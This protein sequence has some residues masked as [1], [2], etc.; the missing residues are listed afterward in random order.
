M[1][2]SLAKFYNDSCP[3]LNMINIANTINPISCVEVNSLK[4]Q[5]SNSTSPTDIYFFNFQN[6]THYNGVPVQRGVA[7]LF[8]SNVSENSNLIYEDFVYR[9]VISNLMNYSINPHFV[10]YLGSALDIPFNNIVNFLGQKN[11]NRN[12]DVKRN[13]IRNIYYA[14]RKVPG[15][16]ALTEN[17][18][19][20]SIFDR[21]IT[22]RDKTWIQTTAKYGY[23]ISEALP[24][25]YVRN[26]NEFTEMSRRNVGFSIT[27][28]NYIDISP[29]LT[30]ENKN[31]FKLLMQL[32]FQVATACYA[33]SLHGL[34]HNDLHAN[35]I[36][37][38]RVNKRINC[39]YIDGQIYKHET[40]YMVHIYDFDKSYVFGYNN[41][42]IVKYK[43]SN[44]SNDLI[45]NRD[46]IKSLCYA[47]RQ[48]FQ[49]QKEK[50][51]DIIAPSRQAKT[52]IE[53]RYQ[54]ARCFLRGTGQ[55]FMDPDDY[56]YFNSMPEIITNLYDKY[57]KNLETIRKTPTHFYT[58]APS[59]F[60][61]YDVVPE[62]VSRALYLLKADEDDEREA[63]EFEDLAD[64]SEE[65]EEVGGLSDIEELSDEEEEEK[66]YEEDDTDEFLSRNLSPLEL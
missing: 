45:P 22:Q 55:D 7:K 49:P 29:I 14:L 36:F 10:K 1:G 66:K 8:I 37:V 4:G 52:I 6:G 12:V 27:L 53:E 3:N 61:N 34:S 65:L 23:I 35:N 9:L 60:E 28:Q 59:L 40:D 42:D 11:S 26:Y 38:T 2:S 58:C 57:V 19:D 48:V 43:S 41:D 20:R 56:A 54:D 25:V 62:R 44:I 33:M 30:E 16:P 31:W 15:R 64:D 47:Y 63:S 13:F 51:L 18:A 5:S 17:E 46:F 24:V 50:L 32:Y 21:G 39:Y